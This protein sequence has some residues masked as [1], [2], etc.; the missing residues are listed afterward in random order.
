M[1]Y[2]GLLA[3]KNDDDRVEL[4]GEGRELNR[5]NYSLEE[6][7]RAV[8]TDVV[9]RLLKLVRFRNEYSAF[10]GSVAVLDSDERELI[11]RW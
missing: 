10:D 7:D 11:L 9:R 6:I 4:T 2:V 3:G 1:Y 8:E 5:H